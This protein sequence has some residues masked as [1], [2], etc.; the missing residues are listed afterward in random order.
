MLDEIAMLKQRLENI[1][2]YSAELEQKNSQADLK[3]AELNS[4]LEVCKTLLFHN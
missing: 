3:T 2:S 1:Q 4:L